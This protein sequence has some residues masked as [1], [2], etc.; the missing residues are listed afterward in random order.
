MRIFQ[1]KDSKTTIWIIIT[2]KCGQLITCLNCLAARYVGKLLLPVCYGE[3]FHCMYGL[4]VS[5]LAYVL[6]LAVLG[7]GPSI[8]LTTNQGQSFGYFRVSANGIN[9]KSLDLSI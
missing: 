8:L 5:T 7:G 3:L 9:Y 4:G 1:T 2:T 6:P